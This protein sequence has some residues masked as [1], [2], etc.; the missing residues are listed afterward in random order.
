M[1]AWLWGM[2]G[3]ACLV[4]G[5]CA[6]DV[7]ATVT[8]LRG[9]PLV[10]RGS[11]RLLAAEGSRLQIGDIVE[12]G[13]QGLLVVEAEGLRLGLGPSTSL[14]AV[15]PAAPAADAALAV[16]VQRGAL[17]YAANASGS[18][19]ALQVSGSLLNVVLRDGAAVLLTGPS[20]AAIFLESGDAGVYEPLA[21]LN[22][23]LLIR[24]KAREYYARRAGTQGV[25]LPRFSPEF[26]AAVPRPFTDDLP[27]RLARY[28]GVEVPMKDGPEGAVMELE[29]WL[30]AFPALR[31]S[32]ASRPTAPAASPRG[33]AGTPRADAGPTTLAAARGTAGV[34]AVPIAK[35]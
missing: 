2:L 20:D 12:T 24:V 16:Y 6:Q 29:H 17:K 22:E 23:T 35:P 9:G 14:M 30:D 4:S 10:I 25:V 15:P 13:P 34:P 21:G 7:W 8:L 28:R 32:L 19:G 31:K 11:A 33:A 26:L 5:A 3:W 27:L 1:K 18:T